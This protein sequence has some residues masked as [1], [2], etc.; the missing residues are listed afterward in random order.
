MQLSAPQ[1]EMDAAEFIATDYVFLQGGAIVVEGGSEISAGSYLSI[2]ASGSFTMAGF[3]G[4]LSNSYVSVQGGEILLKD[5]A[6][7]VAE[8]FIGLAAAFRLT[9]TDLAFLSSESYVSLQGRNIEL[10]NE[11]SVAAKTYI[12][13]ASGEDTL[14]QASLIVEDGPINFE[15]GPDRRVDILGSLQVTGSHNITIKCQNFDICD[16]TFQGVDGYLVLDKGGGNIL[17][18][19]LPTEPMAGFNVSLDSCDGFCRASPG[20][21]FFGGKC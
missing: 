17:S 19:P 6:N 1:I 15:C 7:M 5:E 11:T 8:L 16:A 4:L 10:G 3:T 21:L 9:M 18:Y 13:V 12:T 14:T 2:A 20:S